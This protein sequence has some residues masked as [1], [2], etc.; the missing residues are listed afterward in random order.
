MLQAA[1]SEP[2]RSPFKTGPRSSAAQDWIVEKDYS[3]ARVLR[4]GFGL[5]DGYEYEVHR[6]LFKRALE[7][8]RPVGGTLVPWSVI[9]RRDLSVTVPPQPQSGGVLVQTDIE[10]D[11]IEVL[12]PR[13]VVLSLG[14]TLMAGLKG[15]IGWP[16]ET[17]AASVAWVT[18]NQSLTPSAPSFDRFTLAP[19]RVTAQTRISKMLLEQSSLNMENVVRNNI[20]KGIAQAIDLAVLAGTGID[21]QP[22][23]LLNIAPNA[24]GGANYSLTAPSVTFGGAATWDAVVALEGNVLEN[25]IVSD[26]TAGYALSPQ[27]YTKW[28]TIPRAVGYPLFLIDDAGRTN[29]APAFPSSQLSATHQVIFSPRW[30]DCLIGLWGEAVDILS[31]PYSMAEH[32]LTLVTLSALADCDFKFSSAF[33]YST[34]A[35]NQS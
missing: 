19:N 30:S 22:L 9:A 33:A 14:G 18:E 1:L 27:T 3:L 4:A 31:D 34:D 7:D 17:E 24:P 23:G 35:G 15:N 13:S 12:R 6:E 20:T 32:L 16:R 5:K 28:K 25:N 29:G 21:A 26:G 11:L 10:T 8:G 2:K